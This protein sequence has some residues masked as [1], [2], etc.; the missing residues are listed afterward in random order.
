M[1]VG[2]HVFKIK[3]SVNYLKLLS[4]HT[5]TLKILSLKYLPLNDKD[6]ETDNGDLEYF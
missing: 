3:F 4:I 2:M 1:S 6:S 5:G